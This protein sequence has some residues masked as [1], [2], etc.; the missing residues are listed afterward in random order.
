LLSIT[1][2]LGVNVKLPDVDSAYAFDV[3]M[4]G[5][6]NVWRCK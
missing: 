6:D 1:L 4:R 3:W 2:A 5:E